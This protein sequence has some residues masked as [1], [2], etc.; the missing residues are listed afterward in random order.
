MKSNCIKIF[1]CIFCFAFFAS[2]F[3][4]SMVKPRAAET[5]GFWMLEDDIAVS[6]NTLATTAGYWVINV[7]KGVMTTNDYTYHRETS[8]KDGLK[9]TTDAKYTFTPLPLKMIPG[10]PIAFTIKGEQTS[11]GEETLVGTSLTY[12]ACPVNSAGAEDR[13]AVTSW[14]TGIPTLQFSVTEAKKN[15]TMSSD[16]SFS[17]MPPEWNK[18]TLNKIRVFI[19]N[20][21]ETDAYTYT[22]HNPTHEIKAE[23]SSISGQVEFKRNGETEWED[24]KMDTQLEVGDRVRT[25]MDSTCML[26]FHD[27]ST[28]LLKPETE[29]EIA[30]TTEDSSKFKLVLGKLIANI[31]KMAKDGKMEIA[32]TQAV[33]GIKGTTLSLEFKDNKT[34][35][36]VLEGKVEFT[37]KATGNKVDVATGQTANV[38]T[39]LSAVTTFVTTQDK[40]DW[41]KVKVASSWTSQKTTN[42]PK[43]TSTTKPK[44][45]IGI[46]AVII[47]IIIAAAGAVGFIFLKKKK[48]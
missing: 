9:S 21:L 17:F 33:A 12:S 8:R 11:F 32:T 6:K 45:P 46:I 29:V 2:I 42:S 47:I 39:D 36:E 31:K 23:F 7:E 30:D 38:T 40:T 25:A 48:F 1:A 20:G 24:A 16:T 18:D 27:M 34:T 13:Y 14:I 43:T 15:S 37:C 35:L 28:F 3:A 19:Y 4:T 5:K 41:D 44:N 26:S 22:Y 10:T